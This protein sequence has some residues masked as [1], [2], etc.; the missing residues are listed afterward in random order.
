MESSLLGESQTFFGVLT[1]IIILCIVTGEGNFIL[2]ILNSINKNTQNKLEILSKQLLDSSKK[3]KIY[4]IENPGNFINFLDKYANAKN[5]DDDFQGTLEEVRNQFNAEV[6]RSSIELN[7]D[8]N[9][10]IDRLHNIGD[11]KEQTLIPLYV[12]AYCLVIFICDEIVSWN[13]QLLDHVVTFVSIFTALS[14]IFITFL[15]IKFIKEFSNIHT[16]NIKESN[17]LPKIRQYIKN[18]LI[19]L[20][21]P[22]IIIISVSLLIILI[23]CFFKLPYYLLWVCFVVF[24]IGYFIILAS[25]HINKKEKLGAYSHRFLLI[26]FSGMFLSAVF[27]SA[28][29]SIFI[30]YFV[31]IRVEYSE[32][33]W[34]LKC[35][36]LIFTIL[37]GL[38]SPFIIPCYIDFNM[39]GQATALTIFK[40]DNAPYVRI[41]VLNWI[42]IK[43]KEIIELYSIIENNEVENDWEFIERQINSSI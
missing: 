8:L 37:C 32:N 1:T 17:T 23:D 24:L 25:K 7:H 22:I 2:N 40:Q 3:F 9:P 5:M 42:K 26:H 15:W 12:F 11:A 13:N 6:D 4:F 10:Y 20:I 29:I 30:D 27:I 36:I 41:Q 34:N 14:F 31:N 21:N 19:N 18:A 16:K 39:L 33:L 28:I 35:S 38:I 43:E